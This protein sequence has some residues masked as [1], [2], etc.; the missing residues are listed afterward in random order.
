MKAIETESAP[1][2]PLL[3]VA[4][5]G[6]HVAMLAPVAKALLDA[7]QPILFLALTTAAAHLERLNIPFIGYRQL[8]GAED[9]DVQAYGLHLA[10]ALPAGGPVAPEETVA[11]LGLNYRE[12][13]RAHGEKQ[14]ATL[15]ASKGRQA[16]LPVDLF[17]S[18]LDDLRP[19]MVIATNSPRSE[20]AVLLAAARLGI[21]SICAVDIF[22][23]Q[24]VQWIGQ[25]GYGQRVCVLNEQVKKMFLAHGR[26]EEE[27]VVTGNPAFQRL[28]TGQSRSAGLALRAQR[29][30]GN[31]ELVILWGSQIEPE[32]HPFAE[33]FGDPMLPRKIEAE[34]RDFVSTHPGFRLVVRYHPS[35]RAEFA[36]GQD[37]VDFS[38]ASEDLAALLHA[39]DLVVVTASTVGLEAH[40]AG[41]PVISVD[42][43]VFTPDAP[44]SKMGISVG[45]PSPKELEFA[46]MAIATSKLGRESTREVGE[47]L[48][49]VG[50]TQRIVQV[51]QSVLV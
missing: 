10:Q 33:R 18:W 41:R 37:R 13:V 51:I 5:G 26:H 15:Y 35:E 22:G 36:S 50:P 16:F 7:G 6:G 30:W 29:S 31:D 39:V 11:Y 9:G 3:F 27:V 32:K 28:Q 23:L 1:L 24:E 20:Q 4:Y 42:A 45:V 12:L 47:E 34:L 38:P 14:A 21:P 43:S 17:Q 40:L 25:P 46:L 8:P 44:Y 2:S 49:D 19:A 48:A